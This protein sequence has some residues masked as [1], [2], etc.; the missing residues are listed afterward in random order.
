MFRKMAS[1]VT[2]TKRMIPVKT[3]ARSAMKVPT[4]GRYKPS[5][6]SKQRSNDH[7]KD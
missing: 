3:S 6:H 7:A 1:I 5:K 4:I 2:R